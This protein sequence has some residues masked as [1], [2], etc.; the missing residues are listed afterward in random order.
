VADGYHGAIQALGASS[1]LDGPSRE[2]AATLNHFAT[3]QG[4]T[5]YAVRL[6][7]GQSIGS[8]LAE[9]SIKQ[10]VNPRLKQTGARWCVAHVGPFVE[11]LALADSLEWR[12]H[13]V[14]LAV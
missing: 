4:R 8:G 12:E 11:F 1:V 13:R 5:N 3:H 9:G 2:A 10:P 6:W 7:R 14:A